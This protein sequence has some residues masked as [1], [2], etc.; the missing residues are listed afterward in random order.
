MHLSSQASASDSVMKVLLKATG[1]FSNIGVCSLQSIQY[2]ISEPGFRNNTLW[3]IFHTPMQLET[4]QH[5]YHS[6]SHV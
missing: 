3:P 1:L 5:A 6:D 4:T 2:K